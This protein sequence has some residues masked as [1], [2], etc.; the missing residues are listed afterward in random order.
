MLIFVYSQSEGKELVYLADNRV[1]S[2]LCLL[3]GKPVCLGLF[4]SEAKHCKGNLLSHA[5]DLLG[6]LKILYLFELILGAF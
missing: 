2:T 6:F 4:Q 1:P 5:E 3:R